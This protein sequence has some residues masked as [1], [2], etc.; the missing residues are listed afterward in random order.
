MVESR[1][2][3]GYAMNWGRGTSVLFAAFFGGSILTLI[4]LGFFL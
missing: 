2:G 4:A 3:I 1:F